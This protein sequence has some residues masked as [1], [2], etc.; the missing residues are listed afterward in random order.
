VGNLPPTQETAT[1]IDELRAL[2]SLAVAFHPGG[3]LRAPDS[4]R[5]RLKRVLPTVLRT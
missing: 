3:L 2:R 5:E 4:L 1:A